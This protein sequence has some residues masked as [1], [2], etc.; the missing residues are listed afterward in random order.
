MKAWIRSRGIKV[1]YA[2]K[3]NKAQLMRT[4]A[5]TGWKQCGDGPPIVNADQ[6]DVPSWSHLAKVLVLC[7]LV[8]SHT[9]LAQPSDTQRDTVLLLHHIKLYLSYN[10][11]FHGRT[12]AQ[13][14]CI[15]GDDGRDQY[16]KEEGI[17]TDSDVTVS[18]LPDTGVPA[19]AAANDI[20]DLMEDKDDVNTLSDPEDDGIQSTG[21]QAWAKIAAL[22]KRNKIYALKLPLRVVA[23]EMN[24][25]MF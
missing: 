13:R 3:V 25:E 21:G 15:L 2:G 14:L 18:L 20:S 24:S 8:I 23:W 19:Q 12:G 10:D 5:C 7:E 22:L 16:V 6:R 11:E 1:R 4:I 17:V 9:M